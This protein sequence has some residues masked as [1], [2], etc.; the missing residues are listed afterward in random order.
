[1]WC[2][3]SSENRQFKHQTQVIFLSDTFLRC[4]ALHM[5]GTCPVAKKKK[6][7]KKKNRIV[8]KVLRTELRA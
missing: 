4:A 2:F 5:Y 1:M 7:K 6:K 8:R 3:V